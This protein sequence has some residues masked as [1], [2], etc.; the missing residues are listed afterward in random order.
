[1]VF[2][3]LELRSEAVANY[4]TDGSTPVESVEF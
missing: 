3:M 4:A 1:M 2:G